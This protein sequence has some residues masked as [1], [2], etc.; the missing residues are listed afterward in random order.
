MPKKKTK[1]KKIKRVPRWKPAPLPASFM[2]TA[3]I[4]FFI[5]AFWVYP[6]HTT[7]GVAFLIFFSLMFITSI[8]NMTKSPVVPKYQLRK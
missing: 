3:I 7:W 4:G 2:L 8:I 5:S 1:K 6:L